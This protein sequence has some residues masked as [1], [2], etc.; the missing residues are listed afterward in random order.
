LDVAE[1]NNAID[2]WQAKAWIRERKSF[3][4]WGM[5]ALQLSGDINQNLTPT[6]KQEELTMEPE[7]AAEVLTALEEA[8]IVQQAG[9][10]HLS[11]IA[12]SEE[13]LARNADDI[14]SVTLEE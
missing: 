10:E 1:I 4:R 11:G 7:I 2:G 3:Q 13:I 9:M 12:E 14:E 6:Q 8:G 5:R